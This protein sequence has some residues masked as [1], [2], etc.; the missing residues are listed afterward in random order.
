LKSAVSIL[1]L[2]V[3]SFN[4]GGYYLVLWG[5]KRHAE[6]ELTARLDANLYDEEDLIELIIPLS[7]PYP[8]TQEAFEGVDGKFEHRGEFYKL[9]KQRFENNTLYI[10][11][12]KDHQQKKLV[13]SVH[14]YVKMANDLPATSKKALSFLGKLIKDF[15]QTNTEK[16][17]HQHGWMMNISFGE[18]MILFANEAVSILAPP[19]K[20]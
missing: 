18:P 15:D 16:L 7:L 14:D 20:I 10:L 9:V 19:P 2:I 3:F 4:V 17:L 1:L 11:C 5:L 8:I 12:I 6:N 13:K